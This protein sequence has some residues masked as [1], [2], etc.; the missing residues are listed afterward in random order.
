MSTETQERVFSRARIQELLRI[1]PLAIDEEAEPYDLT[2]VEGCA[3]YAAF[4]DAEGFYVRVR[5]PD[6]AERD[7]RYVRRFSGALEMLVVWKGRRVL[8]PASLA[9]AWRTQAKIAEGIPIFPLRG[10]LP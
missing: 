7:A 3:R 6:Q 4:L 5:W 2:T 8:V 9:K 1:D 10:Y